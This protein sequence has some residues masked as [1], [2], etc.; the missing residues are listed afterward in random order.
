MPSTVKVEI[1]WNNIPSYLAEMPR[2]ARRASREAAESIRIGAALRS[3]VLTGAMKNGWRVTETREG[4]TV[5]N[6]VPYTIFNEYGTVNMSSQPM[7]TPATEEERRQ[8]PQRL[9]ESLNALARTESR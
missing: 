4:L 8:F 7:L 5:D 1:R 9:I 3:R 2:V 6:P